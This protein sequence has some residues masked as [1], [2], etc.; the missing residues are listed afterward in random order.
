VQR[1]AN[2]FSTPSVAVKNLT[3]SLREGDRT[4]FDFGDGT[5][6]DTEEVVHEYEKDGQYTVKVVA[7]REFCVTEKSVTMPFFTLKVPNVIT[8]DKKDGRNDHFDIQFGQQAGMTPGNYGFKVSLLVYN[9]WGTEV[10]RAD[11]YKYDWAGE[12]LAAG[13]YYYEVVVEGHAHCKSWIQIIR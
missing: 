3:D 10:Y 9:R 11:D 13:I 1:E 5:T 6:A 7:V 8:P 12:G 2:C 4:F